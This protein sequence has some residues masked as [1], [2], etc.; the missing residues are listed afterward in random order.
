MIISSTTALSLRIV[1]RCRGDALSGNVPV[2]QETMQPE[3][4]E[5]TNKLLDARPAALVKA[6]ADT[7]NPL[8]ALDYRVRLYHAPAAATP[9]TQAMAHAMLVLWYIEHFR[10]SDKSIVARYLFAGAYHANE[11]ARIIQPVLPKGSAQLPE[12]E[13]L[14]ADVFKA[15][16]DRK[17]QMSKEG[18]KM[19]VKRMERPLNYRCANPICPIESDASRILKQCSGACDKDKKSSYCSRE[20]QRADWKNHKPFCKSGAPCSVIDREFVSPA[21][22]HVVPT[23]SISMPMGGI[24]ASSSTMTP[25]FMKEIKEQ[26][27]ELIRTGGRR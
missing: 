3:T 5:I 8:A 17:K 25:E 24:N 9:E 19:A 1:C 2:G 26:L 12:L 11:S 13:F 21:A 16:E 4:L 20:C 22:R 10:G 7:G 15:F 23:G 18:E 27:D 6:E 14:Y